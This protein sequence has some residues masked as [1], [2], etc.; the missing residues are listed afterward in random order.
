[1]TRDR[2]HRHRCR[3]LGDQVGGLHAGRQA[4]RR[5]LAAQHATRRLA[6]GGVEQDMV[7]TWD[8]TRRDAAR[9]GGRRCRISPSRASAIAV[10]G[11]GD[12][13]WL[14]DRDGEPVAPACSGSIRAPRPIVARAIAQPALRR[15]LSRRPAPASMPASRV[16]AGLAASASPGAARARRDRL[17]LQGLALFQAHRRARHR[18]LGSAIS[19][20]A[21]S[22]RASYEPRILRRAR[23]S[24][25][26]RV[27]FRR[28]SRARSRRIA[29]SAAAARDTGLPT[30]MPVVLGYVDVVCTALGGGL[31]DPSGTVG[32]TI[33]GSTGMHMRL[34]RA[35][36]RCASTTSDRLHHGVSGARPVRADAVEHGGDA[37]H[38]LAAR[39]AR[40]RPAPWPASSAAA[41]AT[42]RR[43]R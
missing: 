10:T 27:C 18:S 37:Q 16:A 30:G 20:S 15:A 23:A 19:P 36:T 26:A 43:H 11:Q 42:P 13:T 33:I 32:C 14:I 29:P 8:D 34:A 40:G 41:Q 22:A 3:H 35:P 17:P 7:R 39:I 1:M 2:H 21:I 6:G 4:D 12:G 25:T 38:R 5:R 31:Y 24:P 28:S 9:A